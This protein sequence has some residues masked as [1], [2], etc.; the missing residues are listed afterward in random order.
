MNDNKMNPNAR[1]T[2]LERFAYGIGD[3]A[4]NLV[5]SA[6]SAFFVGILHECGGSQCSS[7]RFDHC[8]FKNI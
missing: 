7:S 2:F 3:Y 8:N 5:Y 1:L 6:I 4:G